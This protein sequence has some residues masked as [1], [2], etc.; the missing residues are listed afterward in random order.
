MAADSAMVIDIAPELADED[1]SRIY[2]FIE[3]A[4]LSV[5]ETIW[6]SKYDLGVAVMAAH[7]L[8]MAGRGG[9]GGPVTS[10][11]VGDLSRSYGQ[12]GDK[13]SLMATSYGQWFVQLR[14][15]LPI[16]PLCL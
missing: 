14:K 4:A 12:M 11:K 6:G 7:L 8:T 3:F 1:S 13:D 2:R 16:T 10:E 9:T 5:N 15:T